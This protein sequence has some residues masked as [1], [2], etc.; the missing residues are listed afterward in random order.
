MKYILLLACLLVQVPAQVSG[1]DLNPEDNAAFAIKLGSMGL[2]LGAQLNASLE[3]DQVNIGY[4][5]LAGGLGTGAGLLAAY[6][7]KIKQSASSLMETGWYLGQ[8]EG[9]V[10]YSLTADWNR[11]DTRVL[12]AWMAGSAALGALG[13]YWI[14]DTLFAE[15]GP[16]L[17]LSTL[18][19]YVQTLT[20][21]V[22]EAQQ[23][24]DFSRILGLGLVSAAAPLAGYYVT[25][26]DHFTPG[27]AGVLSALYSNGLLAGLGGAVTEPL[28]GGFSLF[29]LKAALAKVS[30]VGIMGTTAALASGLFLV[31]GTEF[32][33]DQGTMVGLATLP[34]TLLGAGT[35]L[36]AGWNPG[37]YLA[38]MGLGGFLTSA[39]LALYYKVSGERA[40]SAQA[41]GAPQVSLQPLALLAAG[42]QEKRPGLTQPFFSIA[43]QY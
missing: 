40:P 6:N 16:A 41:L 14:G 21:L 32:T 7:F 29:V 15:S 18:T 20:G 37:G 22:Q 5:L 4:P 39:G 26:L 35:A 11:Y 1:Q 12:N 23:S 24:S 28:R 17:V 31:W 38:A 9:W 34:G 10:L 13:G 8:M 3:P 2:W 19:G 43:F 33:R 25:T 36:L 27:D 30:G 42:G